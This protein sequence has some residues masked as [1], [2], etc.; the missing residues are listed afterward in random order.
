[1]KRLLLMMPLVLLSNGPVYAEWVLLG[2]ADDG[3]H[4]YVDRDTIRRKGDLVKMWALFDYNAIHT[5]PGGSFLSV[6]M[7]KQFDCA[8]ERARLLAFTDYSGNMGSGKVVYSDSDE[9][10]W[11]PIIP[12]SINQ[13]LWQ[14]A[15]GKQ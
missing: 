12:R 10:K 9:R 8:E 2:T 13:A 7:Q 3:T 6:N 1:M 11:E 5:D 14:I 15:C 4:F